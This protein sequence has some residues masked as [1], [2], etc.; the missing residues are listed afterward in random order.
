ECTERVLHAAQPYSGDGDIV[1]GR[2]F[3]VY[4]TS[5][6]EHV[7]CDNHTD[8]D[9]FIRTDFLH[10]PAFDL[11]AWYTHQRLTSQGIP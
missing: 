3:L 4:G 6:T 8:E 11:A 10:D 2:R 7:I 5:E 9:V 1:E